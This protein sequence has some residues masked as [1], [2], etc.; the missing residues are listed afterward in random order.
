MQATFASP[1][2]DWG[3]FACD[4]AAMLCQYRK[5]RVSRKTDPSY[6]R[7]ML[8]RADT[9]FLIR[10][11]LHCPFGLIDSMPLQMQISLPRQSNSS[12]K[13]ETIKCRIGKVLLNE[14]MKAHLNESP[15]ERKAFSTKVLL[16]FEVP[17]KLLKP[18]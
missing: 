4:R 9:R 18:F 8:R 2:I 7:L 10:P 6:S 1:P 5:F 12:V 13:Y 11:I 3:I 17:S 15:S 14:N 16:S